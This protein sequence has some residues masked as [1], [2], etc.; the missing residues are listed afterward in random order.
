MFEAGGVTPRAFIDNSGHSVILRGE[1][2]VSKEQSLIDAT[3][4]PPAR[5]CAANSRENGVMV[6]VALCNAFGERGARG[7]GDAVL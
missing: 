7:L 5:V 1:S 3:E 2:A 4:V 6:A